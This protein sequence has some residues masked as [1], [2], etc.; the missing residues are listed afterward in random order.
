MAVLAVLTEDVV[1]DWSRIG[2]ARYSEFQQ[3]DDL[4]PRR[5]LYFGNM[6][7]SDEWVGLASWGITYLLVEDKD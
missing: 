3:E 7:A 1:A 5:V 4:S 2:E 6:F